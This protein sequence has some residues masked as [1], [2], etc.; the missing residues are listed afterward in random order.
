MKTFKNHF[1]VIFPLLI[2]LFAIEFSA[3]ASRVLG[4]YENSMSEDYNI[5]VV[6]KNKLDDATL[7]SKIT[8][9]KEAIL[10]DNKAVIDRL[11]NDISEK[12]LKEL[13][14]NLPNFY[15]IKLSVFPSP[16][17]MAQ[18]ERDLLGIS[19]VSKVETFSKT[20]DKVYRMLLIFKGVT[21]GFTLLIAL[22]GIALIFKQM[23]IWLYEHR[24]R[25]EVMTDLGAPYW[26][27]SA[28]LYKLA[29]I[30]SI[31]ATALVCLIY[32]YMPHILS[33]I[34]LSAGFSFPTLDLFGDAGVLFGASI[35]V[36][37]I[38]VSLVMIQTKAG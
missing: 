24:A 13:V 8:S 21:Q 23:R 33:G 28:M 32:A 5:I 11:K 31:I 16:A 29:I 19:G 17:F 6:S 12:N 9:F 37:I 34:M 25:I 20:H 3:V 15:S 38:A 14:A 22:M 7:K 27:R 35:F 36:S 2:L 18:I 30:D 26:L 4:D 1:G 10:L